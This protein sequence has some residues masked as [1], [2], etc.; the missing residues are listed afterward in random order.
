MRRLLERALFPE[1][2]AS[3]NTF[4]DRTPVVGS[5]E[6]SDASELSTG[7]RIGPY[8]LI[9]PL[10]EGGSASV[11]CAER[12]DGSLKRTIALKLPFFVGNTRG[13]HD[14]ALRERDILASLN[15]PNI[16]TIFDAGVEANGRPWLALELIDGVAIDRHCNEQSLD[17]DRRIALLVRVARAVEYAHARGVIHR[18]LKPANILIDRAGQ[19]KLLDFGIAKLLDNGA[20]ATSADPT[21]LTRLHGR[22]FTPEYA[23]PEQQRG[24]AVT[25]AVDVYALGVVLHELIAG[26]RPTRNSASASG[27]ASPRI[28]LHAAIKENANR[29]PAVSFRSDLSSIVQ[30]ALHHDPSKRYGTVNAFADDLERYLRHDTVMAQ[31][32]SSWYRFTRFVRRNR[33]A[34]SSAAAVAASLI[35]GSGVALWQA[36]VANMQKSIAVAESARAVVALEETEKQKANATRAAAHAVAERNNAIAEATRA[37]Q[38]AAAALKQSR[39]RELAANQAR[40]QTLVAIAEKQ[41]AD[42]QATQSRLEAE[43]ARAIKDYLVSLFEATR[44]GEAG[45]E[46]KRKTTLEQTVVE[47][48]EKVSTAFKDQPALMEEMTAL[49]GDL[50]A[51]LDLNASAIRLKEQVVNL[52]K[53]RKAQP[54]EVA[55]ALMDLADVQSRESEDDRE[56]KSID[57]ARTL[58]EKNTDAKSQAIYAGALALSAYRASWFPKSDAQLIERQAQDA[59]MRLQTH[60]PKSKFVLHAH[61]A[62]A[63]SFKIRGEVVNETSAWER[64][65]AAAKRAYGEDSLSVAE[66]QIEL[67]Q[68]LFMRKR[69]AEANTIA[70]EVLRIRVAKE[71]EKSA[72]TANAYLWAGRMSAFAGDSANA[73][74]LIR[75]GVEINA[76]APSVPPID[77]DTAQAFLVE[78]LLADGRINDAFD[79]AQRMIERHLNDPSADQK[80]RSF[81]PLFWYAR[82]LVNSGRYREAVSIFERA[83][84]LRVRPGVAEVDSVTLVRVLLAEA[85][86]LAGDRERGVAEMREIAKAYAPES[87]V[88]SAHFR[89]AWLLLLHDPHASPEEA[90]VS[91]RMMHQRV[92]TAIARDPNS[93]PLKAVENDVCRAVALVSARRTQTKHSL[94]ALECAKHLAAQADR[95][96]RFSPQAAHDRLLLADLLPE[97]DRDEATRLRQL[98]EAS[99]YNEK[100]AAPH[101]RRYPAPQ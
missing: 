16:A 14:R 55:A 84:R 71:G 62:I 90:T 68:N 33:I 75:K 83:L 94:E 11:W 29:K 24:E 81:V 99:F 82:L 38:E 52:R 72:G 60:E 88:A 58:V 54:V 79:P 17:A 49:L 44:T 53:A 57:E 65:V 40:S 27:D 28:D 80:N 73:E 74:R 18:D 34:M 9:S 23:S 30:K 48:E 31:P 67:S 63:R 77:R 4:L 59:L 15:H 87:D 61:A 64:A 39:L 92:R 5:G 36:S 69:F 26:A 20:N 86:F 46:A 32:D 42:K 93:F 98:A 41:R 19:P 21:M 85:R 2:T 43:K 25:T 56:R 78:R 13:W 89:A 22:P 1:S 35:A 47:A 50:H 66:V 12:S 10:G 37:D 97:S 95:V 76:T 100:L 101:F 51:G 96:S 45:A 91:L 6:V 3:T 8:T 7:D 70:E